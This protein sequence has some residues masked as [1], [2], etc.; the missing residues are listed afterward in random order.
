MVI[1]GIVSAFL[2]LLVLTAFLF[3]E[4]MPGL[5]AYFLHS[6][7]LK[8]FVLAMTLVATYGSVS[9]FVSVA[10][11]MRPRRNCRSFSRYAP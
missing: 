9:T 8:G 5:L 6:R 2:A 10:S 1:V 7:N 11:S 4:R 3:R